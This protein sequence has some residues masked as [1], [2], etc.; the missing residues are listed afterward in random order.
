MP[1][2]IISKNFQFER[3][4]PLRDKIYIGRASKNDI[5]LDTSGVSR[6]HA[7]IEKKKDEYLLIDKNSTNGTFIENKR[8]QSYRLIN[9]TSFR[10]QD[11]LLAFV[12]DT[13][14]HSKLAD[15]IASATII[16]KTSGKLSETV[17]LPQRA[18]AKLSLK[19]KVSRLLEMIRDLIIDPTED[20]GIMVLDALF[21]MTDAERGLVAINKPNS[22]PVF[23]HIR[24]FDPQKESLK[25]IR[26]VCQK[27]QESGESLCIGSAEEETTEIS[28]FDLKSVL[29]TPLIF[30]KKTIGCIYLDHPNCYDVFSRIDHD[31][32]VAASDHIAVAFLQGNGHAHDL[33]CGDE[34]LAKELKQ[35]GI[36]AQ[37]PKTLKVFRDSATIAKYNVSVL[38]FGETG[39]GKEIIA[40]YIHDCSNR[41]GK[42][43]ARNC[44]AIASSMFESELFG[45]EKGAFTGAVEKKLGIFELADKG[46]IFLDE[47]GD[48]PTELQVKMLRTIQEQE[49]WRVG[50]RKPISIDVRVLAATHKDIKKN[51]K[52]IHFRDDLY[53]R[54]ANVEITA[55]NLRERPE[56]IAPLCEMILETFSLEHLADKL[57]LLISPSAMRVLEAFDWPGNIRQLRN[58]LIQASLKCDGHVIEPQHLKGLIDVYSTPS[59]HSAA[60]L[61]P[62]SEVEQRHIM[63]ALKSTNWNKSN[64]AKILSIDR[65]R[66]NRLIKKYN[67]KKMAGS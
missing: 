40:R 66:L 30:G 54:L 33:A 14:V 58:T 37:S 27:V 26:S 43:I 38:I 32:L 61:P 55:P 41:K 67:I 62:L 39:T 35:K 9:G 47:I 45:H 18:A 12:E 34:R 1:S 28:Q 56:D 13:L 11:Y 7:S 6:V 23:S 22:E 17:W 42:F 2:V 36:I 51:R 16:K 53:Y 8:V 10:I 15:D 19:Q 60:P 44:S 24:G 21:D 5:V 20:S 64:A 3:V 65:N 50:G 49:V 29:C 46:T 57:P 52:Q 63:R 31:L 59:D 25:A 48:M 4:F